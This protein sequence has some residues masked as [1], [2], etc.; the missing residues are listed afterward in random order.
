V[1][2]FLDTRTKK[3]KRKRRAKPI[4]AAF[5]FVRRKGFA[6]CHMHFY[7]H[8]EKNTGEIFPPCMNAYEPPCAHTRGRLPPPSSL[9][10]RLW[11]AMETLFFG[12]TLAE[13]SNRMWQESEEKCLK[14]DREW[15]QRMGRLPEQ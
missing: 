4:S 8:K 3:K 15:R 7:P 2:R 13:A 10:D 6:L 12:E 1:D 14:I 11:S 5:I 9:G